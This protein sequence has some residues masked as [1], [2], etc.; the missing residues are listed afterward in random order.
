MAGFSGKLTNLGN[1]QLCEL[2]SAGNSG[3]IFWET[4]KPG[5]RAAR[6]TAMAKYSFIL[7]GIFVLTCGTAASG[8][9]VKMSIQSTDDTLQKLQPQIEQISKLLATSVGQS[10][11]ETEGL[12]SKNITQSLGLVLGKWETVIN[13]TQGDSDYICCRCA[14]CSKG[15]TACGTTCCTRGFFCKCFYCSSDK[16][17]NVLKVGNVKTAFVNL[18]LESAKNQL[19]ANLADLMKDINAE[20]S[21]CCTC[22]ICERKTTSCLNTQ[23]CA[24][25]SK[26]CSCITCSA[27]RGELVA[28]MDSVSGSTTL[29]QPARDHINTLFDNLLVLLNIP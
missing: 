9:Q 6:C 1:V 29:T 28:S 17:Q 8:Q 11:P 26:L 22:L 7:L 3:G 14:F 10:T 16:L 4:N 13:T 20:K 15:T 24:Q 2:W 12:I 25:E 18:W 23:C 19:Q 27:G 5:K 21:K